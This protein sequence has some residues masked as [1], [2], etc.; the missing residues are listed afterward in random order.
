V[1]SPAGGDFARDYDSVVN[2]LAAHFVWLNRNK[3]SVALDLKHPGG[4]EALERLSA[5]RTSWFRTWRRA[6]PSVLAWQSRLRRRSQGIIS[7]HLRL[8]PRRSY[9]RLGYDCWFGGGGLVRSRQRR[10]GKPG[11]RR[12]IG[13]GM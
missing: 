12:R 1:E 10:A 8:R 7:R 5:P 4:L 9:A 6:R 11:F 13:A 2:G 3:E